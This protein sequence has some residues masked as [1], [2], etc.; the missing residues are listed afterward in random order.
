[1]CRALSLSVLYS[2][3]CLENYFAAMEARRQDFAAR[4]PKIIGGSHLK[5]TMLDVC[6]NR[7]AKHEMVGHR[8]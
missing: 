3:R 4:G 6:S 7:G 2:V 8:F 1:M 5:N